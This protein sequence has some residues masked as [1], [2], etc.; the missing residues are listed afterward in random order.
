LAFI[1][2]KSVT[3]NMKERKN[4]RKKESILSLYWRSK[5]MLRTLHLL[6]DKHF[7]AIKGKI[8]MG[9]PYTIQKNERVNIAVAISRFLYQDILRCYG[10]CH[11]Y[12]CDGR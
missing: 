5:E 2:E 8:E 11:R 1:E 3:R 10:Y 9:K 6:N 12:I 7:H 4:E